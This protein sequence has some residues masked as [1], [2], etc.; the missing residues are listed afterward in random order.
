MIRG[1][2]DRWTA[3]PHEAPDD[4]TLQDA[5]H[6]C[7]EQIGPRAVA[8]LGALPEWLADEGR[9]RFTHASPLSDMRSFAPEASDDDEEL[10][11]GHVEPLQVFGHTNQGCRNAAG[12][13]SVRFCRGASSTTSMPTSLSLLPLAKVSG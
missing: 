8:D 13:A 6:E 3:H 9:V 1:N 2:V 10:L 12:A 5:I 11:A 4:P 7:R